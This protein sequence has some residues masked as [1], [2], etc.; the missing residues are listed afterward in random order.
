[1]D[2]FE[3]FHTTDNHTVLNA[4]HAVWQNNELLLNA[5][6]SYGVKF[7]G[8]FLPN[9][10]EQLYFVVDNKEM[11]IYKPDF[12]SSDYR[13][14]VNEVSYLMK[15]LDK[16]KLTNDKL[17]SKL[18]EMGAV[19]LSGT[20]AP[21][22]KEVRAVELPA[23]ITPSPPN[24]NKM[25]VT[26]HGNSCNNI[27]LVSK[28]KDPSLSIS[29]VITMLNLQSQ[30]LELNKSGVVYVSVSVR[31]WMTALLLYGRTNETLNL[32]VSP[33][34]RE[35]GNDPGQL[36]ETNEIQIKKFIH[37]LKLLRYFKK[38]NNIKPRLPFLD[39]VLE[40]TVKV[41]FNETEI[42]TFD[43][44]LYS[45]EPYTF[46]YEFQKYCL[47]SV[48][49]Y[50]QIKNPIKVDG[51]RFEIIDVTSLKEDPAE[52]IPEG[53]EYF[54]TMLKFEKDGLLRFY[55]WVLTQKGVSWPIF[56]V[57]HSKIMQHSLKAL[58][59]DPTQELESILPPKITKA[60]GWTIEFNCV[61][62][63]NSKYI[64]PFNVYEGIPKTKYF[65][66]VGKYERLCNS[67]Q[68]H[69]GEFFN[70]GHNLQSDMT[71]KI[72]FHPKILA[73]ASQTSKA[74]SYASDAAYKAASHV[75]TKAKAASS[76]LT[77]KYRG[78]AETAAGGRKRSHRRKK[79]RT[80]RIRKR[81]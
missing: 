52:K 4:Q 51:T 13:C 37:F 69:I 70:R 35:D 19:E 25:F 68:T 53:Q 55:R 56:V 64:K 2:V 14:N 20:S 49:P 44:A 27:A 26:R 36:P 7:K 1:M 17:I 75:S 79:R 22:L 77:Q 62:E 39:K 9:I 24:P 42:A 6:S 34:I 12:Q 50:S 10:K 66:T 38:A 43:R 8:I 76:Y 74:A 48:A 5:D 32:I 63:E 72:L 57:S 3:G 78:A 73:A 54:N 81:R 46:D 61:N 41:T 29:G 30:H 11:Y 23:T 67:D 33:F 18:I 31:T 47:K 45:T 65:S 58:M 28:L 59:T 40:C 60:N 21:K 15:E 80:R 16:L 71:K